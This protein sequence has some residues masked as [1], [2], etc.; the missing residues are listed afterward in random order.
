MKVFPSKLALVSSFCLVFICAAAA[1]GQSLQT[2]QA[3]LPPG[4][5][6]V[7]FFSPAVNRM[8]KFDIV[9]PADYWES[10]KRYSV[11]YLLHGYM[12]NYTVWAR[13]LPGAF[14]SRN[15]DNLILVLPDGGNSW[16]VNFAQNE[17]GQTNNWEDHIIEDVI[18][19]VDKNFRTEARREGRAISGLS[20]GGFGAFALGLRHPEMFVSIGSTS[21]ALSYARSSGSAIALGLVPQAQNRERSLEDEAR[22]AEADL[23]ISGIINI[24][25]FSTQDERTPRGTAFVT[26]DQAKAYDPFEIIYSVPKSQMPHIYIDSGTE[27]GLISDAREMAQLLMINDVPFD[28]MQSSGRHNSEYWRR[29]IGHMMAI[30]HEVM[31]RALGN[32]P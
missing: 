18:G 23:F 8:M 14:Y 25:N 12:Q 3:P 19:Y 32:R 5:E 1:Q 29:S 20:M 27:D 17:V 4:L 16:F 24:D 15:L 26:E 11:L 6:T 2:I 28:F 13:N 7:E 30:Q 9:F 10:E 31:Q 22:L 21:G